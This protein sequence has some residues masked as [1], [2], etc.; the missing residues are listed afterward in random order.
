MADYSPRKESG[1][2]TQ[3]ILPNIVVWVL[4]N[5]FF[6]SEGQILDF[7]LKKNFRLRE[8]DVQPEPHMLRFYMDL[9]RG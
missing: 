5:G 7:A 8:H 6:S 4:F 2:E 1:P 9:S 3:L